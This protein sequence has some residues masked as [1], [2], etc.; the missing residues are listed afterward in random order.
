MWI[1]IEADPRVINLAKSRGQFGTVST[2]ELRQFGYA[3]DDNVQYALAAPSGKG[4]R[5][6]G[7]TGQTGFVYQETPAVGRDL[8]L[9]VGAIATAG[10]APAIFGGSAAA[11]TGAGATAPAATT[12]GIGAT[13]ANAAKAAAPGVFSRILGATAPALGNAADTMGSNRS[14]RMDASALQA[15]VNVNKARED[16]ESRTDAQ[17]AYLQSQY[18]ASG[19]DRAKGPGVSPYS[20]PVT[21]PPLDPAIVAARRDEA[22]KRLQTPYEPFAFDPKDLN[23]SGAEKALGVGSTV[24]GIASAVP[25]SVWRRLGKLIF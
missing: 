13:A 18:L 7:H 15:Q 10:L 9:G 5:S 14:T 23:A 25:D 11:S 1:E 17:K 6:A 24:A 4:W 3:V 22:A 20:K 19:P 21:L 8:A 2:Q 12:T 16:R